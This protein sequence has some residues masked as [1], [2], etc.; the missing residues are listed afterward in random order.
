MT[1][2]AARAA[3]T[4]EPP[5]VAAQAQRWPRALSAVDADPDGE[6]AG[7]VV[8]SLERALSLLLA[9]EGD[10]PMG[11]TELAH[12]ACLPKSTAHRFLSILERSGF[13]TRIG[14]KYT[15]GLTL[16][17]LGSAVRVGIGSD[18]ASHAR[19]VL[20]QLW[21]LTAE[22]VHLAIL[23][24]GQVMYIDK[25]LGRSDRSSRVG[26]RLP[27]HSTA[28]GKVLLAYA[29][30]EAVERALERSREAD[31]IRTISPSR[32]LL[33]DL[34]SVRARGLAI[35]RRE[36][37]VGSMCMAAP[38]LD[39]GGR[40]VAAVS[41]TGPAAAVERHEPALRRAAASLSRSVT[42]MASVEM[43]GGR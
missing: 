30:A 2:Q 39:G 7:G 9:I 1:Q 21:H 33:A 29:S 23:D 36:V 13:V 14:T 28:L 40:A 34:Q 41:V 17:E 20:Q 3:P 19:P 37:Q 38:V 8:S 31:S 5:S 11:V 35:D 22:T 18:L 12:R 15:L 27:A 6:G 4:P 42:R 10:R 16:F 25:L 26:G 24:D 32:P 43:A